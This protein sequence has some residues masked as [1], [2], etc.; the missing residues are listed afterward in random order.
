MIC[1]KTLYFFKGQ[2]LNMVK[3]DYSSYSHTRER[4]HT[5]ASGQ[6]LQTSPSLVLPI[7][8]LTPKF[9]SSFCII[10]ELHVWCLE[11]KTLNNSILHL[12]SR[13]G[14]I[15]KTIDIPIPLVQICCAP[16]GGTLYG[17]C[18]D[19]TFRLINTRPEP[20][21]VTT[22]VIFRS[23]RLL[24]CPTFCKDGQHIL[25]SPMDSHK[26]VKYKLDGT[27]MCSSKVFEE[28]MVWDIA[29][30]P[31]N[32]NVAITCFGVVIVINAGLA[33]QLFRYSGQ[34]H[35]EVAPFCSV[36]AQYSMSG[37]LIVGD[38]SN[39]TISILGGDNGQCLFILPV[40]ASPREIRIFNFV[41]TI[42]S[43]N[44][45]QLAIGHE[46]FV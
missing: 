20:N 28:Y 25:A 4:G 16:N 18:L 29:E 3:G 33:R 36:T 31:K 26:I 2:S 6:N 8:R 7:S 21:A 30:S 15:L 17:T 35:R 14:G 12:I 23:D 42:R 39:N 46:S 41:V 24:D 13:S 11:K 10:S 22:T 9:I 38:C 34:H 40:N 44:P 1:Y 32:C 43:E 45:E 37:N 27:V 19:K 5:P